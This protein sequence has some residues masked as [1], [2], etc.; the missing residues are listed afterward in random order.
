MHPELGIGVVKVHLYRPFSPELLLGVTD[1]VR[2]FSAPREP[3]ATD[4]C[5]A[6]FGRR[7]RETDLREIRRREQRFQPAARGSPLRESSERFATRFLHCRPRWIAP[8]DFRS[9]P[10]SIRFH[11][12]GLGDFS[13]DSD[14]IGPLACPG[15]LT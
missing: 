11:R 7:S 13:G 9:H 5:S 15:A 10:S 2:E 8:L 12:R 14:R 1:K 3:L 6:L 4:V